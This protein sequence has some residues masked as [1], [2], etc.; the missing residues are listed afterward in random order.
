LRKYRRTPGVYFYLVQPRDTLASIVR[1][2]FNVVSVAEVKQKVQE[3][4][5]MSHLGPHTDNVR[6]GQ[7]VVLGDERRQG[8]MSLPV[9]AAPLIARDDLAAVQKRIDKLTT[10]QRALL[11]GHWDLLDQ[12]GEIRAAVSER[13]RTMVET[14]GEVAEWVS[15]QIEKTSERLEKN[16]II[17]G[18][19]D[20]GGG[21]A[22]ALARA[23]K[24]SVKNF[25]GA[26]ASKVKR[27][28]N[29]AVDV[30]RHCRSES[31]TLLSAG[32]LVRTSGY[33]VR[34]SPTLQSMR[35]IVADMDRLASVAEY[36]EGVARRSQYLAIGIGVVNV[37]AAKPG[38]KAQTAAK[39]TG[40]F[41]GASLG[42]WAG[43]TACTLV[44]GVPTGGTSPLW[45]GLIVGGVAGYYGSKG[46]G[47][48][49][50]AAYQGVSSILPSKADLHRAMEK[51]YEDA[52]T[53]PMGSVGMF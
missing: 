12:M 52:V 14:G 21:A 34:V 53:F 10:P 51:A 3:V 43:F 26:G 18:S 44:L 41:V 4:A 2:H 33:T 37:I 11:T 50:T 13:A 1:H 42:A 24:A 46:G 38:E 23:A 30:I 15:G 27:V 22:D 39:E 31:K 5:A 40:S 20:T 8:P 49:A 19:N 17:A 28:L 32:P 48:A 9:P 25:S 7:V 45:C 16:P 36:A 47:A 29:D 35:N 6:P